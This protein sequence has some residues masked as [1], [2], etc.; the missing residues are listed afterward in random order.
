MFLI[1]DVESV[2]D[3]DLVYE[4]HRK[5]LQW[6][7]AGPQEEPYA[8]CLERVLPELE[9]QP[10][11]ALRYQ[12]PVLVSMIMVDNRFNYLGHRTH[13]SKGTRAVLDTWQSLT[14]A[15][16]Q[17]GV[18]HI[19]TFG[20]KQ[21]D[22]PL[23]ELHALRNRVQVPAWFT[24]LDTKPWDNP[25][26]KSEVNRWHVDM[27]QLLAGSGNYGGTLHYWSRAFSLP[28]KIDT[29]GQQV[30]ELVAADNWG[31]LEDYCLCDC[32]NTLGLF[33]VYAATAGFGPPDGGHSQEFEAV[34]NRVLDARKAQS[35]STELQRYWRVYESEIAPF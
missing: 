9:A 4:T 11:L 24:K 28:G 10:M 15:L 23:L 27:Q 3:D 17:F 26:A 32:L 35:P 25:R 2:R 33:M 1:L 31:A 5:I 21:F 29:D 34:L 6:T 7:D 12:R 30:A 16:T 20:G 22:M 13:Y 8:Q 18:Q 14:E 19:I